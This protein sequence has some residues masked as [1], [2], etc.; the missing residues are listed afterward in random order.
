MKRIIKIKPYLL[1][2][3]I[4]YKHEWY[5]IKVKNLTAALDIFAAMKNNKTKKIICWYVDQYGDK[6]Q[7]D[8]DLLYTLKQNNLLN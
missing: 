4:D 2:Y 6:T 8:L 1:I 7:I 3:S 5:H